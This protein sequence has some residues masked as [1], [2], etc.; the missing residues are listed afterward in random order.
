LEAEGQIHVP[1]SQF[2]AYSCPTGFIALQTFQTDSVGLLETQI[3][4]ASSR[5]GKGKQKAR[6]DIKRAKYAPVL[7]AMTGKKFQT[8]FEPA[9]EGSLLGMV[10]APTATEI[11]Y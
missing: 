8:Y 2:G 11:A 10:R 3:T 7:E 9:K 5:K 6:K 4:T 1:A